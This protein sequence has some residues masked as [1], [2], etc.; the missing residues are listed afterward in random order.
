MSLPDNS[1][2]ERLVRNR[3]PLSVAPSVNKRLVSQYLAR[4]L[5]FGGGILLMGG[6]FLYKFWINTNSL[7]FLKVRKDYRW[8]VDVYSGQVNCSHREIPYRQH[9][10]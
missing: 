2:Y 9:D 3:P 6:V 10:F 7:P 4:N 8:E 5:F 1:K